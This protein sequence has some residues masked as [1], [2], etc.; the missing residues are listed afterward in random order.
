[1]LPDLEHLIRLQDIETSAAEARKR[2]ADAPGEIAALDAKLTASRDAVASS[3]AGAA[4][5][6]RRREAASK[7]TWPPSSSA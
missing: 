1:M 2:I 7:R 3:Q 6:I 4:P 5:T